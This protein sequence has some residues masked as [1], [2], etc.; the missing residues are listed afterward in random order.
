[1]KRF[2][3]VPSTYHWKQKGQLCLEIGKIMGKR[4]NWDKAKT[5]RSTETK[6]QDGKVLDN[7]EVVKHRKDSLALRAQAAERKWLR[8]NRMNTIYDRPAS[9]KHEGLTFYDQPAKFDD[10][11]LTVL[12]EMGAKNET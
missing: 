2:Q 1:M 6:Y 8:Q 7:G 11:A 10:I 4:I 3:D 5:Y 9:K 12:E